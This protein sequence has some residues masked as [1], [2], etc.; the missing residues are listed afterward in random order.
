MAEITIHTGA[1]GAENTIHV[2]WFD[3]NN[4]HHKTTIEV[5]IQEQDKPRLLEITINGKLVALI[6]AKKEVFTA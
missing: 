6:S 3:E 5:N 4:V 1:Q 2:D